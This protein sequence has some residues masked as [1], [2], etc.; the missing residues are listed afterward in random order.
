MM[1][2]IRVVTLLC[3]FGLLTVTAG[4][5][6]SQS[7]GPLET[8]APA[9]TIAAAIS[10][11]GRL[12]APSTG[13]PLSGTYDLEF[14]FWSLSGGGSQI[15]A[16]IARNAQVITNGLYNTQLAVD[17]ADIN[18]QELWLQIRVRA[19][20]GTWETLTPRVQVLPT[21]YA[22]SLRPGAHI[23]GSVA[24]P[25]S[26][27]AA[28]NT[29]SGFGLR[30]ESRDIGGFGV[31][32]Y[33]G[34][35]SGGYGGGVVGSV[36]ASGYGVIGKSDSGHGVGVAG[37]TQDGYGVAGYDT[38]SEQ[39][40][41]YGGYFY[42]T[43]GVGAYG[44]SAATPSAGN[45]WTPGVYGSSTNGAGVY[46]DGATAGVRGESSAGSGVYGSTSSG[47]ADNDAGVWGY[48]G[49]SAGVGVRGYRYGVGAGVMGTTYGE[50]SGSG[51]IGNSESYVGVWAES[52]SDDG[53]HARTARADNN[54]GV[55]TPDNLYSLNYHLMGAVMQVVQ[56][57]GAEALE[58][59]DVVVFS[60]MAAPLDSNT[61]PVIQVSKATSVSSTAVAGVVNSRF[62]IQIVTGHRQADGRD[63]VASP[64]VTPT[65]VTK[66]GEYLLLVVQGPAQVKASTLAGAILPGDLLSTAAQAGYAGKA[67]TVNLSGVKTALPGTVF[68]K[69][70]EP[71]DTG[72]ELI[73]VYVTL[74]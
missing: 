54:Y 51:V 20:G 69:A 30:G 42:S 16:T 38:G 31:Y 10:Y 37:Y 25:E 71:L 32:G 26:I 24:K 49:G 60:G 63:S 50:A 7:S 40:R 4:G 21:A 6:H 17:P 27:V 43:S 3:V 56:N 29:S 35:A 46:G 55:Y 45:T 23:E 1:K 22:L 44:Y 52:D 5:V 39:G 9:A 8:S 72:Q 33:N 15:G 47:D 11:Q 57:G 67:T 34:Y 53:V 58:P 65:G 2:T 14:T 41:G 19:T 64:E 68:G 61:P 70:L 62:N 59:G 74:Q 12:V 28:T 73:Y 13:A 36:L 48:A 18:G 66:P